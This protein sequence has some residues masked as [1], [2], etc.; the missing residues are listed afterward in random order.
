MTR[1]GRRRSDDATAL[2][3]VDLA[4]LE[5]TRAT[6]LAQTGLDAAEAAHD[7]ERRLRG[8]HRRRPAL[9]RLDRIQ[10]RLVTVDEVGEDVV[11][12]ERVSVPGMEGRGGVAHEYGVGHNLL[13]AGG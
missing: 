4:G 3:E 8:P 5:R 13:E 2:A 9:R 10:H 11:V 7:R 12:I 6:H 1:N